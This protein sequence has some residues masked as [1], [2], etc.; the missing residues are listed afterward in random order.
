MRQKVLLISPNRC[1]AP[2]AV[3]P[4]GL[5]HLEAALHA[6]GHETRLLDCLADPRPLEAEL[7]AFQPDVVGIS[8]RNLDDV[9]IRRQETFFGDAAEICA[10][11]RRVL[12]RPVVLG[13]SGFSIC[14]ERLLE[15]SGAD[16]GIHGEGEAS[17][18]ALLEALGDGADP[19]QIPGLVFRRGGRI[20]A[21]PPQPAKLAGRREL[22]T[23]PA[24]LAEA[25]LRLS[26]TLNL[27]TQRGCRHTCCYCT[28][29]LIEGRA[30]RRR[31]PDL[32]A[33][34]LAHLETL[35]ARYVF[36]VDSVFN[37]SP[38]HVTET[39]EAIL[40][41]GTRVNWGC[42]LRPQGLTAE[43]MQ[44][45]KRAG[46]SHIEFGSDSFCDAVLEQ[47]GKQLSFADILASSELARRAGVEQC[48]FLICGG[49]GETSA[50]LETS[51]ANSLRLGGPVIMAVVGMRI[52][53]GTPLARRAVR[54]GRL[55]PD[56]DLLAPAYYLSPALTEATVFD[57]LREFSRRSPNWISGD[58][59]ENLARVVARLR[60]RGI[61][62]PLWSYFALLQRLAPAGAADLNRALPAA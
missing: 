35:G 54:E 18:L 49:P 28:Y 20:V 26:G 59:P 7:R 42:F 58:P 9:L 62:G 50:T 1:T 17:F 12:P 53:P 47:Y 25:Y 14:P 34:E 37:S 45:M 24:P 56:A 39:C 16:F 27:Q 32:V 38:A 3:Y 41:R 13:G 8:V 43:L 19:T 40:R 30:H 51:Y 46:L 6:A 4:L 29:P 33:E 2:E 55:A 52:Y 60:Q 5:A 31:A 23:R 10:T 11:V 61:L 15:R 48:H 57:R 36:F 44:L 21:N 22:P